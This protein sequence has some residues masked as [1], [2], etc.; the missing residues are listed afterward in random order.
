MAL[1][2]DLLWSSLRTWR[3]SHRIFDLQIEWKVPFWGAPFKIAPRLHK[4]WMRCSWRNSLSLSWLGFGNDLCWVKSKDFPHWTFWDAIL[5]MK[6]AAETNKF[7]A[8]FYVFRKVH[9]IKLRK[10]FFSQNRKRQ[11]QKRF[12]NRVSKCR[13]G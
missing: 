10:Q 12:S 3:S 8:T 5:W 1:F 13:S 7:W 4:P 2:A 9:D 11:K 6:N